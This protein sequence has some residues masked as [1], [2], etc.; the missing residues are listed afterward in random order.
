MKKLK[1][2]LGEE[3]FV[4]SGKRLIPTPYSDNLYLRVYPI[5]EELI[6][7]I[8]EGTQFVPAELTENFHIEVNPHLAG[9]GNSKSMMAFICFVTE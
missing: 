7:A 2:L 1:H 5:L 6:I 8:E 3:L 4:L 9:S